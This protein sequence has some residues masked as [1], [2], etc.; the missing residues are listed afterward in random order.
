[1]RRHLHLAGK[2]LYYAIGVCL[3]L[4]ALLTGA[5]SRAMPW[6]EEHP[7]EVRAWLSKRAGHPVQFASVQA[8]WTRR[9]PLL[10]LRDLKVGAPDNPLRLGDA[11]L[12]VSQYTGWLPGNRLTE[13][14]LRGIH[15]NLQ[16]D[17]D[18]TWHV[19][20]LPGQTNG[21]DPLTTLEPLG[22][23][24]VIGGSL[25]LDAHSLGLHAD[26]PR[27][28]V[29]TQVNGA[30]VRVGMRGWLKGVSTPT[31]ATMDFDRHSG[32][33]RVYVGSRNIDLKGYQGFLQLFGVA[34]AGG[35]G[36]GEA[37]LDVGARRVTKL[38]SR[39]DFS[40]V[41]LRSSTPGSTAT[42]VL[43]QRVQGLTGYRHSGT[44]WRM[45]VP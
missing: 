28:D 10:S 24:Q 9:G 32:D 3:L 29:R 8:R 38:V 37:W 45:D 34:L 23:L 13:L 19:R 20:G 42:P 39:N 35:H 14:R 15:V 6:L 25:T 21:G 4:L 41:L 26:I 33:G 16:R 36:S 30:R 12:L 5:L 1:M 27:I 43:L 40:D 22:E 18:G 31:F 17:D 44:D 11:E 2:S 7:N